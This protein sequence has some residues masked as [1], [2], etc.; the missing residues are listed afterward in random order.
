MPVVA[1]APLL[2]GATG[3]IC[4]SAAPA[5]DGSCH[6]SGSCQASVPA[7]GARN[8]SYSSSLHTLSVAE[9]L[10]RLLPIY[11]VHVP[12]ASSI[13]M[14]YFLKLPGVCPNMP[15]DEWYCGPANPDCHVE[16]LSGFFFA[17]CPRMRR[18][19]NHVGIQTYYDSGLKGHGVIML[20][21]PEQR[22]LSGWF[23]PAGYH[24]GWQPWRGKPE[25]PLQYARALAGATVKMLT[26]S[27]D[28][29]DH[30][31]PT[32]EEVSIARRRL[33]EGFAF[34]GILERYV[35]SICLAHAM[36]GGSC[37]AEEFFKVHASDQSKPGGYDPSLLQGFRDTA[38]GAVYEEG[39]RIFEE[40]LRVYGVSEASCRPCFELA[41]AGAQYSKTFK[42]QAAWERMLKGA[43]DMWLGKVI[44]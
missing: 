30:N 2:A 16:W 5:P 27:T 36:F 38:D 43:N 17:L 22:L 19:S 10:Q 13:F 6:A 8:V 7:E 34:V 14:N 12:K 39:M 33:R 29:N 9:R 42:K 18:S 3:L 40:N 23:H 41:A 15:V 32:P 31:P 35:M 28:H 20:R 37:R 26:R 11:W 25:S 21:Q 44:M 24:H 1:W 4:I